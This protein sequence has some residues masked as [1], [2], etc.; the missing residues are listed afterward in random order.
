MAVTNKVIQVSANGS[1]WYT[2]PGSSGDLNFEGASTEDSVFGSSYKS[3][4]STLVGATISTNAYYKGLAGYVATFKKSGTATAMTGEAMSLVS[5][6]TY[7]VTDTAKNVFSRNHAITV[8][9]GVTDVT[10]QVESVDHLFGRVTF[11]SSYTVLGSVTIDAYYL[12][13]AS[14]GTARDFTLTMNAET[15]DTTDF[16]TAQAN[17]GYRTFNYGLKTVSIDASG[18]Y[19]ASNG[20]KDLVT[21]RNELIIEINPDGTGKSIARGFFKAMTTG[22]SGDNG[23]NEDS[24]ITFELSVPQASTDVTADVVTPFKW[25]DDATTTLHDSMQVVLTAW[26]N[27]DKVYMRYLPDGTTGEEVSVVITDTSLATSVDG[28]NEFSVAAQVDG[29][30][31]SV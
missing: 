31:T 29:A 6:K 21:G 10:A 8:Y 27:A 7:K 16:A 25:L 20:F 18:F 2:F 4:Q 17:G 28:I 26:Q 30:P 24:S 3:S 13:L 5:G 12:P 11:L 15:V 1:T 19:N 23:G 9:D 22:Q 14:V